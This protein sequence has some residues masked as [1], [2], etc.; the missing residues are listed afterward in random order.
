MAR[1]ACF[2]CLRRRCPIVAASRVVVVGAQ[3][4]DWPPAAIRHCVSCKISPRWSRVPALWEDVRY[5]MLRAMFWSSHGPPSF[6]LMRDGSELST[7]TSG[8]HSWPA[9]DSPQSCS[10]AVAVRHQPRS[11]P[12]HC[13][14]AHGA[15]SSA[16]LS[17]LC[18]S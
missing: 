13:M 17:S 2:V 16:Q 6:R 14:R 9:R 8:P 18:A 7:S 11:R 10:P 1:V 15:S 3:P 4:L 12:R 5:E